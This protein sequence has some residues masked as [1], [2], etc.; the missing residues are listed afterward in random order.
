MSILDEDQETEEGRVVAIQSLS[1][2]ELIA[3]LQTHGDDDE[4]RRCK[5][6]SES[7]IAQ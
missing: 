3:I 7:I 6:A 5:E 2:A 4:L 1:N